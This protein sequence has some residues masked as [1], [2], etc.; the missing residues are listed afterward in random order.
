MRKVR[1]FFRPKDVV[2]VASEAETSVLHYVHFLVNSVVFD[3]FGEVA[4]GLQAVDEVYPLWPWMGRWRIG[5]Y[6]GCCGG[7]GGF[8]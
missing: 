1:A 5:I 2:T 3:V 4:F 7:G 8:V 6:G